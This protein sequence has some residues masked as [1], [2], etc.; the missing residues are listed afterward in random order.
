MCNPLQWLLSPLGHSHTSVRA[1]RRFCP[2]PVSR[3]GMGERAVPGCGRVMD[4]SVSTALS[5]RSGCDKPHSHPKVQKCC[6]P[7]VLAREGCGWTCQFYSGGRLGGGLW[8]QFTFHRRLM[9]L[10]IP[11]GYFRWPFAH[12]CVGF[13]VLLSLIRRSLAY[14]SFLSSNCSGALFRKCTHSPR[15]RSPASASQA[16]LFECGV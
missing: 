8:F 4:S 16:L 10:S 5:F 7:L 2:A 9:M 14:E 3:G 15:K 11:F 6:L 12:F 1:P 13:L